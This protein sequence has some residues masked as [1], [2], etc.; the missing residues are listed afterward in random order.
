MHPTIL[1]I[2]DEVSGS[3]VGPGK[4]TGFTSQGYPLVNGMATGTLTRIDGAKYGP[5]GTLS[6]PHDRTVKGRTIEPVSSLYGDP[7]PSR[8]ANPAA[9]SPP[10]PVA[11]PVPAPAP[12]PVAA[13]A[14]TLAEVIESAPLPELGE[15]GPVGTP[16]EPGPTDGEA[17]Y[18]DAP[19]ETPAETPAEPSR[20]SSSDDSSSSSSS[21]SDSSSSN[22]TS[23]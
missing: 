16:G 14:P 20:S 18:G 8:F 7:H 12:T 6:V 10:A 13:P 9:V 21:S 15:V 2:G 11:A 1:N 4:V 17:L 22:S 3:P 23:E 5:F 19:A